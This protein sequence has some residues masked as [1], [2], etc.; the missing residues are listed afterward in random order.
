MKLPELSRL[1]RSIGIDS[2]DRPFKGAGPLFISLLADF[3][4]AD[5]I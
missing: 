2:Q 1:G 4:R 5:I 3:R